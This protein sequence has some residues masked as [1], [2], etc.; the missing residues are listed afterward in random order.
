MTANENNSG[1]NSKG[2]LLKEY[3][4]DSCEVDDFRARDWRPRMVLCR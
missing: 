1:E 4:T 2:L 3:V